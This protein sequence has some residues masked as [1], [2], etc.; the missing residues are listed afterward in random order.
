MFYTFS[1]RNS[2]QVCRRRSLFLASIWLLGLA[3]G[4]QSVAGILRVSLCQVKILIHS[5]V[6]FLV[7]VCVLLLPFLLGLTR[8]PFVIYTVA[9]CD[10][11]MQGAALS[12][13][14]VR[15]PVSGWLLAALLC[16]SKFSAAVVQFCFLKLCLSE[17]GRVI[18]KRLCISVLI[19]VS[20]VIF[21]YSLVEPLL[22]GF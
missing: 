15:Y 9:F 11:F 17:E 10:A 13:F 3:L 1:N 8:L 7:T 12:C 5:R 20:I 19:L 14:L 6:P 22:S 2:L 16:F 4:V 21:D 18:I